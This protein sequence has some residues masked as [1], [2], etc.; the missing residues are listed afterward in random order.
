MRTRLIRFAAAAA[1]LVLLLPFI[2]VE[3]TSVKTSPPDPAPA[4]S[5]EASS[6]AA[7]SAPAGAL[8]P[9]KGNVAHAQETDPAEGEGAVEPTS[10]ESP[11][12]GEGEIIE[13]RTPVPTTTPGPLEEGVA[14]LAETTGLDRVSFLGLTGE[15]WMNLAI[16]LLIVLGAYLLASW[17][18][19]GPIRRLVNRSESKFDDQA[20]V[21]VGPHLRW[22]IV[23]LCLSFATARLD[24][25]SA[26]LKHV[27]RDVYFLA[28]GILLAVIGFRLVN[29]GFEQYQEHVVPEEDRE[30]LDP[31]LTLLRRISIVVLVAT[32]AIIILSH[33]GVN[34]TALTATL[35]IAG[36]ALSLAAQDTL[37]DAISGF[38][39]LMD[40]PFRV[41]DR[42]E[43]SEENTW[44]D[45]V[46]IGSRTTRIRTRDNR[47]VIVPNSTISKSQVVNYTFPDPEYR[48][49]TDIGI[50][51][52]NDIEQARRI[53]ID[54]VRQVPD[55][56]PD[57]PV[58]ALYNEM[59]DSSMIFRVRW[60]IESYEDTR[61][62]YDRVHT[63]LQKAL[64]ASGIDMPFPTETVNLRLEPQASDE[65]PGWIGQ[66]PPAR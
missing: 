14:E 55:V 46:E 43:I 25:V 57:R 42:I 11:A 56:L 58:D 5:A 18:L 21:A 34:V 64:D 28:G 27:L 31:I 65:L 50:G 60:W 52:G 2:F 39:I 32:A 66:G 4:S 59:G 36:L 23:I 1:A 26:D 9:P 48:V 24:F 13:E 35:G 12:V 38:L 51:Y 6:G 53:I 3:A 40:Q 20:L 61:R 19:W 17:L 37:S 47:M 33:F 62:I 16:S 54:T 22:L 30:R 10:E 49:Q 7:V 44:G 41:G 45:V 8:A 63:A 29:L 15:E